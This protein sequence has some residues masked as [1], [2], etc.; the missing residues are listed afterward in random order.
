MNH[1]KAAAKAPEKVEKIIHTLED[2]E[3]PKEIKNEITED[4]RVAAVAS[5]LVFNSPI[6]EQSTNLK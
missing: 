5:N 6:I 2:S 1:S 4:M 3:N